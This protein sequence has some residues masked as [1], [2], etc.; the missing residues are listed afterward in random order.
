M[1]FFD[2]LKKIFSGNKNSNLIKIYVKDN[3]CGEKIKIVLRKGYDIA[4]NY[5]ETES[6]FSTKKVAICD[7]CYNKIYINL[8]FDKNYQI[9]G[10]EIKNGELITAD[11]YYSEK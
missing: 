1:G 6:T 4:R 7:N 5:E 8:Q 2:K 9:V 10:Q 3:K 11:E